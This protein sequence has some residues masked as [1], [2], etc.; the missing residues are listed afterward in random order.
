MAADDLLLR[1]APH[2]P[3]AEQAVLGSMLIDPDCIKDVMDKLQPEDFY[4]RAN[5]DIFE[6][7]YHMF[8][9]SRPIDGVTVAGGMERNG[10]YNDNTRDYLVQLMDVTPTSANVMEYVKIV[11]DKSLMRQV[12]AAAGSITAMVQEGNGDAGDMLE[13]AEQKVYAI[14]RGRSAQNMVTVSMVLQ[15]VMN[16]LAELTASGGKTLPGLSTGLS[17]VDAKINGL[18]KSDLLL[19]AARPG[20]G[21]TSM[22]LNV[23][24]SAA[25]E[26]GKT[27]AIFSLEMSREQL[28]TRLIA[29]EGLVENTRLVTGNLRES[30]WQRIAEAASSLSRMDIRIDD[31]PLLTVADMNAKCRRLENLGLVVI[32]Y[33]QLMTSAG[34]KG[35]SGENR[36]QAVSDISR[37]LKI[38]AK[39]LQ[40]PVLCLSQLSRANEK[41]DDKRPML[42]DLRESGAIEQDAD[43]VLF[44]YR[45]DYYNSDSEKR[46]V[47]ECIVAKNRHGETG[48]VELRWMPEYT[49]FGTL[50][51]RYDDEE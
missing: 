11:L 22:A 34:G 5:R 48:K 47:A 29:S 46:N 1:Q 40:V 45:D 23:A 32:D 14:R 37:M 31:N 43:I 8:I 3:Q 27:V 44:L 12:A 49:A 10:V 36:Q 2:S 18:N 15:D 42:S 50:E 17:A 19:L 51:N 9:Y 28:V 25:K 21:K 20:M 13:S 33:L 30:D 6:T 7:I 39:E 38:M 35:Y 4:L 24:L 26:S 16:H 41:R